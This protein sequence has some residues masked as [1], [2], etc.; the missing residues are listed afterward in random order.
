MI[1]TE[2]GIGNESFIN[3]EIEKQDGSEYR[4]KGNFK[5]KGALVS[6]YIRIWILK[7]VFILDTKDGFKIK[8]KNRNKFKALLGFRYKEKEGN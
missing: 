2:Y 8:K 6:I 4:I 5:E 7:T 1:Y 3:T